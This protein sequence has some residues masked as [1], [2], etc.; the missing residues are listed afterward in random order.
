MLFIIFGADSDAR[1]YEGSVGRLSV[2]MVQQVE[3][4]AREWE[5][6]LPLPKGRGEKGQRLSLN[7]A[8]LTISERYH[9]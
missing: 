6:P 3:W 4:T 7:F 1:I 9:S 2:R 8:K 5:S